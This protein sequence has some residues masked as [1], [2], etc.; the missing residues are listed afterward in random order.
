VP[1][2]YAGTS[3]GLLAALT[4]INLFVPRDSA[5]GPAVPVRVTA[6]NTNTQERVTI[7]VQ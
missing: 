6:A 1:V 5:S 4:Q 3:P 2:V 7:A